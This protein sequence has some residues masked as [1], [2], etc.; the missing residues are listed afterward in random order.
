MDVYAIGSEVLL[1][2][3]ISARVA[4]IIIRDG[5]V[6]YEVVW[7]NERS[8]EEAEVES[9]EVRPDSESARTLRVDPVL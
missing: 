3:D 5:R 4:A 8:R 2:N 9:W 6:A 1:D 7:W